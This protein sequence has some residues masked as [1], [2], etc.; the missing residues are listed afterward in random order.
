MDSTTKRQHECIKRFL[1]FN[2]GKKLD[3]TISYCFLRG[4]NLENNSC[5]RNSNHEERCR[6]DDPVMSNKCYG[7]T[8]SKKIYYVSDAL[9]YI[10]SLLLLGISENN[11]LITDNAREEAYK[12]LANLFNS[13][14]KMCYLT[15]KEDDRILLTRKINNFSANQYIKLLSDMSDFCSENN[16]K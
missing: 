16:I 14:Q 6:I 12:F 8:F 9:A 11:T 7:C 15:F 4:R 13:V 3:V 5:D 10:K 2:S 1:T